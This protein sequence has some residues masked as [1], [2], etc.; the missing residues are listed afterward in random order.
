MKE[1]MFQEDCFELDHASLPTEIF[2]SP[3]QQDLA[4]SNLL[5]FKEDCFEFYFLYFAAK[6][7]KSRKQDLSIYFLQ[8]AEDLHHAVK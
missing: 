5:V 1:K 3:R 8:H 4:H 7:K 6:K 2:I